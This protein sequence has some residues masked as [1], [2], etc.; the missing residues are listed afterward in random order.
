[1]KSK[2]EDY[3]C[4]NTMQQ[5]LNISF[6]KLNFLTFCATVSQQKQSFRSNR[7]MLRSRYVALGFRECSGLWQLHMLCFACSDNEQW[8]L[9]I[10]CEENNI[11]FI[12]YV[13]LSESLCNVCWHWVILNSLCWACNWLWVHTHCP[14]FCQADCKQHCM[15]PFALVV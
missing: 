5:K 4:Q 9:D 14:H 12:Y 1:M 7:S 11:I 15:N 6:R 8:L 10:L 13:C 2:I 3:F